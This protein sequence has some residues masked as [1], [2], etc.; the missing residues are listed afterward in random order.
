MHSL[1]ICMYNQRVVSWR[2]VRVRNTSNYFQRTESPV[3]E[4]GLLGY[5]AL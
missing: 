5:N 1:Y 2:H 4:F 3:E